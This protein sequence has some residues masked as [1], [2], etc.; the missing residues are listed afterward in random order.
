MPRGPDASWTM[1]TT[2]WDLA[3]KLG[4]K[5]EAILRDL[6]RLCRQDMPLEGELPPEPRTVKHIVDEVQTLELDVLATLP[7]RVWQLRKDYST[8]RHKLEKLA[9]VAAEEKVLKASDSELVRRLVGIYSGEFGRLRLASLLRSVTRDF[10]LWDGS[11][12]AG[13]I[14]DS[15]IRRHSGHSALVTKIFSSITNTPEFAQLKARFPDNKAWPV[16]DECENQAEIYLKAFKQWCTSI[17]D[18][19]KRAVLDRYG[20]SPLPEF[21]SSDI[22][23]HACTLLSCQIEQLSPD[24][25]WAHELDELA[26]LYNDTIQSASHRLRRPVDFWALISFKEYPEQ[27]GETKNLVAIADKLRQTQVSILEHLRGLASA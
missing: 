17:W 9:G 4:P 3:S 16:L 1:M 18:S 25:F 5:P 2:I 8:I 19:T 6:V 20:K 10:E 7:S 11:I 24:P 26:H 21:Q 14:Y 15:E 27:L 12:Y 22:L 23:I 13:G